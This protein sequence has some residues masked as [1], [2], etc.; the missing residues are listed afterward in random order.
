MNYAAEDLRKRGIA[1][2]NIEYRG[3]DEP[4]GGYPGTFQDVA[5]GLDA[6]RGQAGAYHLRLD[7]VV[8][9]GHSAGGH[10]V[11]WAAARA[12]LPAWS[13]LRAADP[14]KFSAIVDLAGIPNLAADTNTACGGAVIG[15]LVGKPTARPARRLRRHI[16]GSTGSP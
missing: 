15:Q 6:V 8:A 4:G 2:W 14:L 16:T 11:L 10:L 13:M 3:V 1:V 5:A 12:K 7:K 9:V